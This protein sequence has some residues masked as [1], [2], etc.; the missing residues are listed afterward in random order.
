MSEPASASVVGGPLDGAAEALSPAALDQL[1]AD[2]RNWLL[3]NPP[4]ASEPATPEAAI[5]LS[6]LLAP[7]VALRHEVNLQTR[8]SRAQLEQNAQTLEQ[9]RQAVEALR[10]PP[11]AAAPTDELLR[12][13]LKTLIDVHDALTLA[14]REVLRLREGLPPTRP[15]PSPPPVNV[16]LPIWARL[17]GLQAR[18][19]EALVPL[20]AWR[21][22]PPDDF[23]RL[24]QK[25]D[26]LLTGYD[27]GLARLERA[28]DQSG[29]ERIVCV[30]APFDPET[31]EV[32][33]VVRDPSRGGTEVIDELR[34][35]YRWR[36]RLL[37]YAQ[38]RVARP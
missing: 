28:L 25:V 3:A 18:V 5:D 31:M 7:F 6:A 37:R 29:L 26:A 27:M 24:R 9:L 11:P 4:S 10:R 22:Q 17:L 19:D 15:A 1:L 32:A 34:P 23:D 13:L 30:G 38:V 12:P 16:H 21:P 14:R 35:G 8:A 2:F 20:R 33:E 36:D